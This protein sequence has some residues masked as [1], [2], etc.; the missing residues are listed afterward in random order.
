MNTMPRYDFANSRGRTREITASIHTTLPEAI[1]FTGKGNAWRPASPDDREAVVYHRVYSAALTS[2]VLPGHDVR[3]AHEKLPVSL[4]LPRTREKGR[5]VSRYGH[6]VRLLAS[7]A[8]ATLD[9]RRIV[10]D[11]RSSEAHARETG[12][13]RDR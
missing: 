11:R 3:Y 10:S 13:T 8:Y 2:R 5:I 4:S 6:K 12:Y 1:V 7:G 9:G